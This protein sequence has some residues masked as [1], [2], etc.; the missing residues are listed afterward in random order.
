MLKQAQSGERLSVSMTLG[1]GSKG[2][3]LRGVSWRAVFVGTILLPANLY[4]IIN[5]HANWNALPTTISLHFNVIISLMLLIAFN[6]LLQRFRP[7]FSLQPGELL[8]I[9]VMLA[10]GSAIAGHDM[11]QTIVPTIPHAFWFATPENEWKELF[12]RFLPRWLTLDAQRTLDDYYRGETSFYSWDHIRPWLI[13]IAGWTLLLFILIFT[14]ICLNIILRRQWIEKERLSYPIIQL[15]LELARGHIF[16][17]RL[18]WLGFAIAASLD[19]INGLHFLFPAI[20]EIPVRRYEIGQLFTQKPWNAIGWTPIFVL[21]FAVG[22][23]FLIPLEM[24]FSLWFFYIFWKL[25]RILGNIWGWESLPRF[26]YI[27]PQATGAYLAL[28]VLALWAARRHFWFVLRC[29]FKAQPKE[30]DE[31]LS[32]RAAVIGLLLGGG[33]LI[34]LSVQAGMALWTVFAYFG[35]YFLLAMSVSRVRAEVGPPTHE[36]FIVTPHDFLAQTIGTRR[37]SQGSLTVIALYWAFN[38]GYRAHP[39]P[40][41]LEGFKLAEQAPMSSRK[42]VAA[43]LFAVIIGILTTFWVYLDMAYK[44]GAPPNLGWGGYEYLRRWLYNPTYTDVPAVGFMGIGFGFT[45]LIWLLRMRFPL[46]PLHPA[47]YAVAS[48]PWTFGWLWFSVFLSW[49]FKHLI[50]KFGGLKTYRRALPFFLGLLL[51]DYVVGGGWAIIRLIFGIEVYVFY[52]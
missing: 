29:C 38:R 33:G 14:M 19:L 5:N 35:V 18:L 46:W 52:R 13:P 32:Y 27:G 41:I 37:F 24:S 26:P 42:L 34:L 44:K 7:R 17:H 3:A 21:P 8:T 36:M 23:G 25:E 22:M 20:P 31:P 12:W 50:L 4:F 28:I 45:W 11:M 9:Y 15:P 47:G 16:K 40:H 48:S 2:K 39:M 6:S 49:T 51:G 43:M 30:P 10:I 1:K